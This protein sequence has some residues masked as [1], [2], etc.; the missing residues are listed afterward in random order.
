MI[1]YILFPRNAAGNK[2]INSHPRLQPA[3]RKPIYKGETLS[4]SKRPEGR[5]ADRPV[6]TFILPHNWNNSQ[7][8]F[9]KW[10][11]NY[12]QK[13][14]SYVHV[15][16]LLLTAP[17]ATLWEWLFLLPLRGGVV[18]CWLADRSDVQ[19]CPPTIVWWIVLYTGFHFALSPWS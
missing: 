8:V 3:L 6:N 9:Y 12:S 14:F 10:C 15:W 1:F 13:H 11:P 17:P 2:P 18:G 4:E 7:G 16:L 19:T 5:H